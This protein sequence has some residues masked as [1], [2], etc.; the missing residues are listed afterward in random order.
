MR[1]ASII[2]SL[3]SVTA[4]ALAG[5]GADVADDFGNET[6]EPTAEEGSGDTDSE[7]EEYFT[8][9]ETTAHVV[10]FATNEE[11]DAQVLIFEPK[12]GDVVE[13]ETTPYVIK[14]ERPK[15]SVSFI[16][17]HPDL[18]IDSRYMTIFMNAPPETLPEDLRR[19]YFA[20]RMET[21]PAVEPTPEHM[22]GLAKP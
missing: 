8:I 5:E 12:E 7:L 20:G 16:I 14:G 18:S 17:G 21:E 13:D 9:T 4:V 6:N 19:I 3:V 2:L 10:D 15:P 1:L 11:Y 22:E